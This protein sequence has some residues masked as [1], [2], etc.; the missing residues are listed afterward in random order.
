VYGSKLK[1]EI[2]ITIHTGVRP[3]G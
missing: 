3:S 1:G 2:K